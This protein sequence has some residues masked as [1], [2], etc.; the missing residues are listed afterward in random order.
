MGGIIRNSADLD[1]ILK[2]I[3]YKML[4][5]TRDKIYKAIDKSI[6]E[7][8]SEFQPTRYERTYKFLNSLVKTNIVERGNELYCEVKIDEDYLNYT[9]PFTGK[10][11]PS[12]P[13]HYDGRFAEGYDVVSWANRKF[14]NDEFEGGTHGFTIDTGRDDGFWD[15]TM[16]ELGDII[17]LMKQNIQKQGIKLI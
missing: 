7:Y 1:K 16:E 15:G 3:A 17:A 2:N 11:N 10:Y 12:Y 9:Y 14:P 8:Y 4:E 13:H 5:K 6:R